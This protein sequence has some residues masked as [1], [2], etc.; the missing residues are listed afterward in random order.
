MSAFSR[1]QAHG[2]AMIL[3]S[4]LLSPALTLADEAAGPRYTYLGAGYDWSE[5][6]C[7]F[8]PE[9]TRLSGYTVEGS[10]GILDF[11]HVIGAYYDGETN[12]PPEG[13]SQKLDG[14][15]YELG[16]GFSYTIAP[17]ADI[18]LR[19]YW[20]H[21]DIDDAGPY[22]GGFDEDGFEPELLVRYAVSEKTEVQAGVAY[23]DM[24]DFNN[25]EIRLALVHEILPWLAVRVGGS[26]FDDDTSLNAG[27]RAYFGGNLF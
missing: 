12:S 11:L 21:G 23:Y 17:G 2:L 4:G 15:C 18:V 26:V 3:I 14:S 9:G 16:V 25:T 19:G 20:V 24:G 13:L 27:V 5:S 22:A 7:A 8:E 10:V 1:R 6:K